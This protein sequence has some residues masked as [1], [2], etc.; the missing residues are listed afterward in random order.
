MQE[1]AVGKGPSSLE[2]GL[3]IVDV[4]RMPFEHYR[5]MSRPYLIIAPAKNYNGSGCC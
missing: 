1:N 2:L 5:K 3:S 4:S